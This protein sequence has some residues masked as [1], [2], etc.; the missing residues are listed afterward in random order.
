MAIIY[1]SNQSDLIDGTSNSD[2]IYSFGGNDDVWG[3]GGYDTIFGDAGNDTLHGGSGA[4]DLYGG[5]GVNDLWGGSGSDWFIMSA[6]AGGLSDDWIGDFQFDIDRVDVSDWGVSDFSQITALLQT[7]SSGSAWFDANYNGY[8]HYLTVAGVAAGQLISSD[9][10]YSKSGP[11]DQTGT[12]YFDTLFGSAY[13][14]ILRGG[15]GNDVLLGGFGSDR[16][17]GNN[18]SDRLIGGGGNDVLVGG[19]GSDVLRG[20]AGSDIFDYDAISESL[21]ATPDRILDFQR[22]IDRIDVSGVDANLGLAGNQSFAWIG[23]AGFSAAGQL[24][25]AY[26]GGNTII[27]GNVGGTLAAD[28]RIVISGLITPTASDFFL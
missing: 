18:A 14:D 20:N 7:D 12:G 16:L 24:G 25:Y 2:V 21:L 26:S 19:E 22:G 3:Y 11:V 1:G 8:H 27:S 4:D 6:R 28:F 17:T 5:N 10:I 15:G 9:F 13:N 23:A